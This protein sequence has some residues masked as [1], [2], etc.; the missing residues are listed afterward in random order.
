MEDEVLFE[1]PNGTVITE[2]EAKTKY[3]DKFQSLIDG[4]TLTPTDK[5]L[6]PKEKPKEEVQV[7]F[8]LEAFYI[9][10]N[11][12]EISGKDVVQ[13]YGQRAQSLVDDGTLKKKDQNV[14][15]SGEEENM[16]GTTPIQETPD[17]LLESGNLL[18]NNVELN[19]IMVGDVPFS[20]LS[21][22]DQKTF[23]DEIDRLEDLEKLK[24]ARL[25]NPYGIDAREID[26]REAAIKSELMQMDNLSNDPVRSAAQE[27]YN[28]KNAMPDFSKLTQGI[29]DT[30]KKVAINRFD[31]LKKYQASKGDI[32]LSFTDD[33][34]IIGNRKT[35]SGVMYITPEV[36]DEDL[37]WFQK[38]F[39]SAEEY[40]EIEEAKT[41]N[42]E[43]LDQIDIDVSDYQAWERENTKKDGFVYKQMQDLFVSDSE[44]DYLNDKRN[45]KKLSAYVSSIGNEIQDDIAV[46]ENKL[47]FEQTPE[48]RKQLL[49][50]QSKLKAAQVKNIS[51]Q[52]NIINL[53]PRL[54]GSEDAKK[55]RRE[56]YII[57][58]RDGDVAGGLYNTVVKTGVDSGVKF[59]GGIL[60]AIPSWVE[61]GGNLVGFEMEGLRAI[62][63]VL[64]STLNN[65]IGTADGALDTSPVERRT[66]E[67][68]K[69]VTIN[70]KGQPLEVGVTPDGDIVDLNTM[71]SMAGILS[72]DEVKNVN[73]LAK[74]VPNYSYEWSAGS[75]TQGLTG[76]IVNL[77]GLIKGGKWATKTIQKGIKKAG[78]KSTV[79]GGIG[80]GAVSYMSTVASEVSDIKNQLMEAGVS[81]QEAAERAILYGNGR[82]SLDGIFSGLAGGNTKLLEA[83]KSFPK[84]LR[85]L[86]LK[87]K[88]VVSSK[89]FQEKVKDLVKENAK[90]LFVEELPVLFTG[91]ALNGLANDAVGREILNESTSDRD[92][93]ETVILTIGATSGI[94]SKKLL[95]NNKRKDLIRAATQST[96]IEK[97]IAQLVNSGQMSVQDGKKVYQEI[98]N[99]QTALNQTQGSVVMSGNQEAAAA[100]LN[101]RRKL[102]EQRDKLEGPL[103][104]DVDKKIEDVD[105]QI[106]VL[107]A[108]DTAQAIEASGGETTTDVNVTKD[109]ALASLKAENKVRLRANL[110]AIIES[111]E[112][113]LKEQDKL[114]KEKQDA[115]QEQQTKEKVLSDDGSSQESEQ[116]SDVELQRVG[117]RDSRSD[118]TQGSVSQQTSVENQNEQD[119]ELVNEQDSSKEVMSV[120]KARVDKVVDDIVT[121]T[122]GR[123][124][125]RGNKNNRQSEADNAISYLEQSKLYEQSNDS[126]R[127]AMVQAINKKLGVEI[128]S[129]T[130]RQ[131][132]AKKNK[133][134]LNNVDEAAALKDQIKLEVKAAKDA[135]KD[136]TTRR[137]ALANAI[138]SLQ[139]AGTITLKKA[140]SLISKVSGVNLNNSRAVA[141]V[142]DY[143]TKVNNDANAVKKLKD[144]DT[145]KKRIKK[146]LRSKNAE[147]T[148]ATSVEAFLRID[149]NLVNDID[150]YNAEAQK[151]VEGLKTSKPTKDGEVKVAEAVDIKSVDKFTKKTQKQ[152]T[153]KLQKAEAE[154]FRDL[155]GLNS[156]EFTLEEMRAILAEQKA[157]DLGDLPSDKGV[158]ADLVKK[159]IKKAFSVYQ[160]IVDGMINNKVDPFTGEPINLSPKDLNTIKE[161][162]NIDLDLLNN[163]QA[164]EVLDAMVNFSSNQTTGGMEAMINMDKGNKGSV[165]ALN[166]KLIARPLGSKLIPKGLVQSWNNFLSQLPL[167]IENMFAGQSKARLFERLS[168]FAQIRKGS[169]KAEKIANEIAK[170]YSDK[171]IKPSSKQILKGESKTNP[172]GSPFNDAANNTE[173]GIFAFMRRT[174]DGTKAEQ[175]AEFNRRK[176]LVKQTIDQLKKSDPEKAEL[177]QN[178]YDKVL[179]DSNT[180]SDLDSKVDPINKEAVEWMTN[181]WTKLRP[182]LENTSLNVYNRTLGK[183]LNYTPDSFSRLKGVDSETELGEPV[184]VGTRETIYDK[185]TGVLMEK[186]P[187]S[188]L[189][190]GRYLNLGF[191]SI[192]IN[193]LKDAITDVETAPGIQQLKGFVGNSNYEKIVPDASDRDLLTTRFKNFVN[194]KRGLNQF[195]SKTYGGADQKK[196]LNRIN[197]LAGFGVSRVLG[198]VTQ[199]A[200]QLTPLANTMTNLITDIPSVMRGIGLA[201]ANK[202]A[203]TW[204]NNS[205]YEIAN[206][207][208]QSISNLEG[209][210]NKLEQASNS[211]RGKAIDAIVDVQKWWL[212]KFLVN[213]DKYAAKASWLAYYSADLKKQGIDPAGIDWKNHKVNQRAGDYA[214]QQV[215]RQQ[216]TSDQDLQGDLFSSKKPTQQIV[217]KVFFPFANF[218]L[219]QKTRMYTDLNQLFRSD[220]SKEDRIAS[221]KSIAGLGVE[222]TVFGGLGLLVTQILAGLSA[223]DED[224]KEK[225]FQNR[226]KG[227]IGNVAKDILSPIPITDTPTTQLVNSVLTLFQDTE[228]PNEVYQLFVNDKKSYFD[229]M[230]VLGIGPKK[231]VES[232]EYM[233]MAVNGKYTDT[234]T[235]KTKEL[236]PEAQDK[237]AGNAFAYLLYNLGLLPSEVGSVVNYNVKALKKLKDSSDKGIPIKK[238][239]KPKKKK[240]TKNS[241]K[242]SGGGLLDNGG[243]F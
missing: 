116:T 134:K 15:S 195:D 238:I 105:K 145:L 166:E 83:T 137:K 147:G 161:F 187:G 240:S 148:V 136:Q 124:K 107:K 5:P 189:P 73:E 99:M 95:S 86:A 196:L 69:P 84:I 224:D 155:T 122:K 56:E 207:G 4:G 94:G 27:L 180:I 209:L 57:N 160:G 100:L 236:T 140:N 167:T 190:A 117:K 157:G 205:G 221:G 213:P 174:L 131:I 192:N 120:N 220:V 51:R 151:I 14:V 114:I 101:Q 214:Q 61:Q 55:N 89:V 34:M 36:K 193:S 67:K 46:I 40:N 39:M 41:V 45:F 98:Y 206:R 204:L 70:W 181:E 231:A 199:F 198:G 44:N 109:D 171:F 150:A 108:E 16:V 111:E 6:T 112:N 225:A 25:D 215:A 191:D 30:E 93:L 2:A 203:N 113:I 60:G 149:P 22:K 126:E 32:N 47:L 229:M 29:E 75:I 210:D 79:P 208:I 139:K 201:A 146:Q 227:R 115:I 35:P 21:P 223:E 9:S 17:T 31:L 71:V 133:K 228:D 218:L 66:V 170:E 235:K 121:K 106:E 188:S 125:R 184:F 127:E 159:G 118:S 76:T 53:F 18:N 185:E 77:I 142:L 212:Q 37:N 135:K 242:K 19:S 234:F 68:L 58:Q 158:K 88:S 153:Q 233:R 54:E 50:M 24:K 12:T 3:S 162:M 74:K 26:A 87:P 152:Q 197:K 63:E 144:A 7:Q 168:G 163:K 97:D 222:T 156:N 128:P 143:V 64:D 8:D 59:L 165:E 243:L 169:S 91:N 78:L 52:Y 10:P 173:R 130:K 49:S 72:N 123:N 20:Q 96:N 102:M 182:D 164:M 43:L 172:N 42:P 200:K 38:L 217:R 1:T 13:K 90:E 216:N 138:K 23:Y 176:G 119:Q 154:S 241:R 81:E 202:D 129:P 239:P 103:K 62:N 237:M 48:K 82:A 186:R 179:K 85:D 183:D 28:K 92:V 226:V 177:Y 232:Y 65:E 194:S 132:D 33:G 104:K 141:Q 230:G 219:N 175:K 211:T 80:M 178:A 110:P 11:G